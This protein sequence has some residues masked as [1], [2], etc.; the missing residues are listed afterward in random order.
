MPLST[1]PLTQ[2]QTHPLRSQR[3]N[4]ATHGPH[5]TLDRQVK[6]YA[7][8]DS[9]AGFSRFVMAQYW[10]QAE[11]TPV[12]NDPRLIACFPGLPARCR[13]SQAL[14]DLTD[15]GMK[16][17]GA[18]PGAPLGLG[19]AESL[20]WLFVSEG[21]KLGAAFLIRRAEALGLSADK[22]ARHLAEPPGGRAAGWK[23]FTQ[24]LDG[25]TL[26]EHE[27]PLAEA[28]ALAAFE[29]FT[30]LLQAAFADA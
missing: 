3:L 11:L 25:L 2:P 14:A 30:L 6:A 16:A 28:G 29:R 8:F 22:G 12:Y 20:G 13:A 23:A 5:A 18:V 26:A 27:E 9:L 7:P 21:S 19:F 24:A 15:L 1:S 4:L 17:P 10:F